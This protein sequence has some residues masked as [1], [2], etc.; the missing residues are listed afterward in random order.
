[1]RY[2]L[3]Q[4]LDACLNQLKNG[5]DLEQVLARHPACAD[6]LRPLLVAAA[7][8]R[9]EV[10]PPQQ[11]D[12]NK[13]ALLAKVVDRRRQVE[14]VDGYVAALKAGQT[15]DEVMAGAPVHAH[16]SIRAAWHM[17]VTQPPAPD[18][19]RV[20]EGKRRIMA[21]AAGRRA[22]RRRAERV[23]R[24]GAWRDTLANLADGLLASPFATRRAWSGALAPVVAMLFL[25]VGMAGVGTA[26]ASSQPG[27]A[28]YHVKRL[29]ESAQLLF[30]FDPHRRA[31]LNLAFTERRLTEI[32]G[33]AAEGRDVPLG[34]VED[35]LRG[36]ADAWAAIESLP[37]AERQL[38]AELLLTRAGAGAD[39][40]QDVRNAVADQNALASLLDRSGEIAETARAAAGVEAP[41]PGAPA[42]TGSGPQR[43]VLTGPMPGPRPLPPETEREAPAAPEPE[44]PAAVAPPPAA[45]G[46]SAPAGQ[47]SA[48]PAAP[49]APQMAQPADEPR[50]DEDDKPASA[51]A[52]DP[53]PGS[54]PA[55][56][57]PCAEPPP[58]TM[59]QGGAR[60]PATPTPERPN[61][62]PT[63]GAE[64]QDG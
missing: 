59:G 29:G 63:P 64:P 40:E 57:E 21:M 35:W 12:A 9:L 61:A 16:E 56:E 4:A 2:P 30:A 45:Q 41:V 38:M 58:P 25:L 42:S 5:E 60:D 15:P 48:A 10:P 6:E 31:D 8:A 14:A 18:P 11:R 47:P 26:A 55:P 23:A 3:E 20:A 53:Q 50:D 54:A 62:E 28:I 32:R 33:L 34:L 36:Q 49:S 52:G 46:P 43:P 51:S 37:P 24:L 17:H 13:V 39:L 22:A 1:V 27:E 19:A 44:R 7:W